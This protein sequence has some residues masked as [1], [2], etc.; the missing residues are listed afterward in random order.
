MD[1]SFYD[2]WTFI[3][4]D[5]FFFPSL[6]IKISTSFAN[7]DISFPFFTYFIL[8]SLKDI[9]YKILYQIFHCNFMPT[10]WRTFS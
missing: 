5:F 2:G 8:F 7:F 9:D 4:N 1:V 6:K 3:V 10:K